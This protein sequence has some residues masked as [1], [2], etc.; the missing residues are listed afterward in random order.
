MILLTLKICFFVVLE[1]NNKGLPSPLCTTDQRSGRLPATVVAFGVS[2]RETGSLVMETPKSDVSG[3]VHDVYGED[4]ATL[5]Q[6]VTPWSVSVARYL[7]NHIG[8]F[9]LLKRI[10]A[11]RIA[12]D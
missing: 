7:A 12:N 5:D 11:S 8:F 1:Q 4:T 9:L 2:K 10:A 3:G 6:P